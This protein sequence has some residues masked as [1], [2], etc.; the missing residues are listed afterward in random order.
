MAARGPQARG[1]ELGQHPSWAPHAGMHAG[2]S[3]LPPQPVFYEILAT[4]CAISPCLTASDE[5]A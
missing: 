4:P 3:T 2:G 1:R 5:R